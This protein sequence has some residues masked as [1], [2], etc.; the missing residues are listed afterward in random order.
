MCGTAASMVP[1]AGMNGVETV[2]LMIISGILVNTGVSFSS[3]IVESLPNRDMIG[4]AVIKN[5]VHTKMI[6]KAS[7]YRNS[8]C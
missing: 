6:T 7:I 1:Q 8:T 4:Q 3:K 2:E 5:S